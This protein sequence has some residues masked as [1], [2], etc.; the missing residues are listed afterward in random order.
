[1]NGGVAALARFAGAVTFAS[2]PIAVRERAALVLLDT[3][4]VMIFGSQ[5]PFLGQLRS[6]YSRAY[7]PGRA[8]VIGTG[9]RFDPGLAA[10]LNAAACTVTQLS[11]GHRRSRGDPGPHIVP[12]ALAVAEVEGASGEALLAA[13]VAGYEVAVRVGLA[14][15]PLN[16]DQHVHGHWASIGAA[17]AAAKL[18]GGGVR[19]L[20]LAIEG[21]AAL[22][23]YAPTATVIEGTTVHHLYVGSGLQAAIGVGYGIQAGMT[24]SIGT[25][26]DYVSRRSGNSFDPSKLTA[27]LDQ[28][29]PTYEILNN[30]FKLYPV[31]AQVITAIEAVD[32]IC[33]QIPD[34]GS[35]R[36]V[37]VRT[38]AAAAALCGGRDV[39]TTLA[40]KFSIPCMV[41]A[42]LLYPGQGPRELHAI[43][44]EAEP[45]RAMMRRI[46][47][48]VDPT[49]SPPYPDARPVVVEV[50]LND[51]R[52]LVARK[53]IPVG[54]FAGN[55]MPSSDIVSKFNQLVEPI[56]GKERTGKLSG[57]AQSIA[58]C[59][60][61]CAMTAIARA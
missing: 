59:P 3:L 22:L 41:A 13:M 36:A 1:M 44:V 43:D 29:N 47:I 20:Q 61:V 46:A 4:G 8:T 27:G 54:D 53:Q 12:A 6:R 55:P 42:R 15:G 2:L 33:R 21:T 51:G 16:P 57:L 39:H 34:A 40:S 30:Y 45:L 9:V 28:A 52:L 60:D 48:V 18:L 58:M 35:V 31:C 14:L 49:L 11:E 37:T 32:D 25:L 5:D 56:L 19:E 24:A 7:S 50:E 17:V 26:E 10:L 38:T 23:I